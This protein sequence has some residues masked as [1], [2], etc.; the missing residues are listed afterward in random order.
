MQCSFD[1]DSKDISAVY[2]GLCELYIRLYPWNFGV[3]SVLSI[4]V[5]SR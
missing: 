1:R 3:L 2:F 5:T 4:R